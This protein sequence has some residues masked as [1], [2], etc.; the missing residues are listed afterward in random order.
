M[1][2]FRRKGDKSTNPLEVRHRARWD[3]TGHWREVISTIE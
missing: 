1:V 3:E 2:D